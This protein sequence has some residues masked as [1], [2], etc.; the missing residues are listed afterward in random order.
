MNFSFLAKVYVAAV[1][2]GDRTLNQVP[3]QVYDEVSKLLDQK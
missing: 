2:R 1:Q 3:V